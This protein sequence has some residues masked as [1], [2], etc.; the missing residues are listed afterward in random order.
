MTQYF[1][2]ITSNGLVTNRK[3][4]KIIET[5]LTNKGFLDNSDI[6]LSGDN[7]TTNDGKH[8]GKRF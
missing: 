1:S 4:W 3:F 8:L 6:M 7:E 2:N 5:F